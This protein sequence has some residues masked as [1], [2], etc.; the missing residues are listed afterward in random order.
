M[1]VNAAGE[2]GRAPAMPRF[3][4]CPWTTQTSRPARPT[5]CQAIDC[6]GVLNAA[7]HVEMAGGESVSG[8]AAVPPYAA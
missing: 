5:R 1:A 6:Y 7:P 4:V 8:I 3:A 2:I